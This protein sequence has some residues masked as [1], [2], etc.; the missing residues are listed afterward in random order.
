MLMKN[1]VRE[2]RF[3]FA[4]RIVKAYEFLVK[5]KKNL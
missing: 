4:V 5:E 2:K 1:P 3:A